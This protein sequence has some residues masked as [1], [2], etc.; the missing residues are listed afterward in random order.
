MILA[1]IAGASVIGWALERLGLGAMDALGKS[2]QDEAAE[3]YCNDCEYFDVDPKETPCRDC[4][5]GRGM[6]DKFRLRKV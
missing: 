2:R 3:C 6:N 5:Q 4:M 1:I